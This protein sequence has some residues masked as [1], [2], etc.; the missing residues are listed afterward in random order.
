MGAACGAAPEI[1]AT[2]V[3]ATILVLAPL[4]Y[5]I[6]G[7]RGSSRVESWP[8]LPGPES[9]TALDILKKRYAKGEITKAEF[10][11]MKRDIS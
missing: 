9:E 8:P 6:F 11:Q 4:D 2:H 10:E 1:E 5:L 3:S 7:R